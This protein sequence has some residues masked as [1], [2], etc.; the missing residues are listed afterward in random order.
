MK[1]AKKILSVLL[2]T[3]IVLSTFSVGIT[4]NAENLNTTDNSPFSIDVLTNKE[5]YGAIGTAEITV[6]VTNT[7]NETVE[8]ISAEAIFEQ[9]SPLGKNCETTASAEKL[10]PGESIDF[11]YKATVSQNDNRLNFFQKIFLIIKRAFNKKVEITDNGFDDGRTY[12]ENVKSIK[13]GNFN[14]DNI[15][16][17]W[18]KEN[19]D[20]KNMTGSQ[21]ELLNIAKL[22][23][24]ELPDITMNSEQGIPSFIDGRYSDTIVT[25]YDT[26]IESLNDIKNIMKFAN[27]LSEFIPVVE[28]NSGSNKQFKLQQIYNGIPVYGNRITVTT[29]EKGNIE[30]INGY[31]TP[32]INIDTKPRITEEEAIVKVSQNY[33][34]V[35]SNGLI[36]Y[37]IR[38]YEPS[39]TWELICGGLTTLYVSAKDGHI[40]SS[41]SSIQTISATGT[42]LL[43]ILRK[44]ETYRQ[45]NNVYL[46]K[47]TSKGI[48]VYNDNNLT[49]ESDLNHLKYDNI[50]QHANI[51]TSQNNTWDNESVQVMFAMKNAVDFYKNANSN[52]FNGNNLSKIIAII[53]FGQN[54]HNAFS[55][56]DNNDLST[57]YLA[58]GDATDYLRAYDVLYHEFTHSIIKATCNLKY[59]NQAGAINEAYADILGNLIENK[60]NEGAWLIAEDRQIE[61]TMRSLKSPNE[62]NQPEKVE[63]KFM[64]SYCYE[65]HNHN[66]A[67]CDNGGVHTN[68]GIINKAA[69]LMWKNGIKDKNKLAQIFITSMNYMDIQSNFLDCRAAILKAAKEI[70]VTNEEVSIIKEAFEKVGIAQDEN[71]FGLFNGTING[72]V[73]DASTK[74]SILNVQ[75]IALKT[76]P[77]TF[78]AGIAYPDDNGNFSVNISNGRY[79]IYIIPN[80]NDVYQSYIIEGVEVISG[81]I[82]DIGTIEL[83][84]KGE[85]NYKRIYEDYI[86]NTIIPENGVC[87]D[88]EKDVSGLGLESE[89]INNIKN[90]KGLSS[91]YIKDFNNDEIPE[92]VTVSARGKDDSYVYIDINLYMLDE[93][94]EVVDKGIIYQTD[95]FENAG[96]QIFVFSIV[97]NGQTYLCIT[98]HSCPVSTSST[99]SSRFLAYR[100]S[101]NSVLEEEIL[102]VYR[103]FGHIQ[104]NHNEKVCYDDSAETGEE[105]SQDFIE[106][107]EEI[108]DTFKALGLNDFT[109]YDFIN[110]FPSNLSEQDKIFSCGTKYTSDYRTIAYLSGN[111]KN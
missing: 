12:I 39:L 11:S 33:N 19:S 16:K 103:A 93:N 109:C 106:L 102:F 86:V 56:T 94:L 40:V 68:S 101:N 32:N 22:N 54:Y 5:K 62:F 78:G 76:S 49:T 30:C 111:Y 37:G 1:K 82:N 47:D 70:N 57:T 72:K 44:I 80:E 45:S 110:R 8:N 95:K 66:N 43:G 60:D 6:I 69:Y 59:L 3:I 65:N 21:K 84:K 52:A 41:D 89:I 7:S 100:I 14:A 64:H 71:W 27:P 31:Y 36:I 104:I 79:T 13:F 91:V 17:V 29:D 53:N 38:G 96:E 46:L 28:A 105:V 108:N 73:V 20:I 50:L 18:Y 107:K 75:I 85:K 2:V 34:V 67:D 81:E 99:Q 26:A 98:D 35:K 48:T 74:E 63:G 25:G 24:G 9:L 92:M 87:E 42:D 23:G 55:T 15:V 90:L 61:G 88:Y 10:N 97:C 4:I 51:I 58:I 83:T 77:N